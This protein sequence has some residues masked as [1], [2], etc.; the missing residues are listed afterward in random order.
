M[1]HTELTEKL[2]QK[3]GEYLKCEAE[4]S[5]RR[6]LSKEDLDSFWD[7]GRDE[8]EIL[9]RQRPLT[10]QQR[11]RFKEAFA[12]IICVLLWIRFRESLY[13]DLLDTL[14]LELSAGPDRDTST[15]NLPL[16]PGTCERLFGELYVQ[17]FQHEQYHFLE[18]AHVDSAQLK[19][20]PSWY[21][22]PYVGKQKIVGKGVSG[23]V[24]EVK[25]L[26]KYYCHNGSSNDEVSPGKCPLYSIIIH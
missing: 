21:P 1:S 23:Q 11:T 2:R 19:R 20:Y 8:I 12:R 24:F 13:P 14:Q 26:R 6:F 15:I 10:D 18:P 7:N 16:L 9:L 22:L 25:I 17:R 3:L 4:R 5:D